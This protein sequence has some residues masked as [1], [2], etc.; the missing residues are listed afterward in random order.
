MEKKQSFIYIL[1]SLQVIVLFFSSCEKLIDIDAPETSLSTENVFQSDATAI[2][3]VTALYGKLSAQ[4]NNIELKPEFSGTGIFQG[5][6]ADEL[7]LFNV[8]DN[9][10]YASYFRNELNSAYSSV[11]ILPAWGGYYAIIY[12]TNALLEGLQK[13]T[14]LSDAVKNELIGEAKFVRAFCYFFLVNQYG[15]VPLALSSDYKIN[16]QLHK[17]STADIYK[18]IIEDLVSA[19]ELLPSEYIGGDVTTV[20]EDRTRPNSF[21]AS[22]LLARVYLYVKDY[23]NAETECNRII[24]NTGT[25]DITAVP[26]DQVFLRTSKE[27]IWALQPLGAFTNPREGFIY[28]LPE[29]GPNTFQPFYLS[30]YLL[31]SFEPGDQRKTIWTASVAVSGTTY[32]YPFK[33]RVNNTTTPTQ[34]FI[35]VFRLAEIYLIRAEARGFNNN[36]SGASDDLN[37]VRT[38]AGLPDITVTDEAGLLNAVLHERQTEL[39]LEWGHRWFDLKRTEKLDE[40]M[41]QVS[42]TKGGDWASFKALEPIPATELIAAPGLTGHQN[43]GYD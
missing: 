13:S 9:R 5:L 24:E 6:K 42:A 8:T 21:V 2:G 11:G 31:N 22:A 35:N 7:V 27:T 3:A 34:E 29:N 38:R 17:S 40:V 12:N 4:N 16:S 36:F 18:Q 15:E 10:G 43:P 39:F 41:E 33:Y 20:T 30:E 26:L 23:T 37:I 1:F 25:F 32:F 14:A 28:I 19:K